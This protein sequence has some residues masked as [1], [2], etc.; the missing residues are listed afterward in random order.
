MK[1][2]SLEYDVLA[3]DPELRQLRADVARLLD[4]DEPAAAE[5]YAAL[6]RVEAML[7]ATYVDL[8]A[9]VR[10]LIRAPRPDGQRRS[11]RSM[12]V[13]PARATRQREHIG[14]TPTK[15][16]LVT[17]QHLDDTARVFRRQR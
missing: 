8:A 13:R 2:S 15:R 6:A 12:A 5:L 11:T 10:E 4:A 1:R 16:P 3:A 14:S 17:S 9:A 7:D